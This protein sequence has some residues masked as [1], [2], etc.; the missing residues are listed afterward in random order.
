[1]N[2]IIFTILILICSTVF[3]R[4]FFDYERLLQFPFLLSCDLLIFMGPQLYY[5]LRKKS[6]YEAYGSYS[7]FTFIAVCLFFYICALVGYSSKTERATFPNWKFNPNILIFGLFILSGIAIYGRAQL[8]ALPVELT[9]VGQWTGLPVRYR[10]FISVGQ[11]CIPLG[12]ILFFKYGKKMVL[13]PL[14]LEMLSLLYTVVSRGRRSPV[15][16][17]G[18]MVLTGLWFAKRLKIP[19]SMIIAGGLVF[20]MFVANVGVYR[21][22]V[23]EGDGNVDWGEVVSEVFSVE[24]SIG[25][26]SGE[27]SSHDSSAVDDHGAYVDA[28][29]GLVCTQAA[30]STFSYNYGTSLWNDLVHSWVPGQLVGHDLKKSLQFELGRRDKFAH[31]LY[32]Y[33]WYV[34]SCIPGYAEVFT[35]FGIFG[36]FLMYYMGRMAR[37]I[38]EQSMSG[39][40]IA[41]TFHFAL[42]P[43]YI[44]FGGGGL[45]PLITSLFFWVIFLL[46]IYMLAKKKIGFDEIVEVDA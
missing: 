23:L 27:T 38:W 6:L 37:V 4:A 40:L 10:F 1:M 26:F 13:F 20:M 15:V 42:A 7:F 22:L 2:E 3:I 31:E 29:N 28:M 30:F 34:G 43:V 9:N 44:R 25:Q 17:A 32:E 24:R 12:I 41:Q 39:N 36:A 19:T 21:K 33:K 46:P 45:W 18:L 14:V 11:L 35:A 8:A 16:F 5:M